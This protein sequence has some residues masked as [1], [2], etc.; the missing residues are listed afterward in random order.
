MFCG[1]GQEKFCDVLRGFGKFAG[2]VCRGLLLP[3]RSSLRARGV[4]GAGFV[5]LLGD[6]WHGIWRRR[7]LLFAV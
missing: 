6:F 4:M 1:S 3:V 5:A 7:A 2:E